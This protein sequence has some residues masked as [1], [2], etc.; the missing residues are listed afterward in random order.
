VLGLLALAGSR[1]AIGLR[2]VAIEL[3]LTA[4]AGSRET[5]L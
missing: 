2:G 5:I 1:P 4:L 3:G